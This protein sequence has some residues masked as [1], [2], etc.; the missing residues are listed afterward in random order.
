[1]KEE[2]FC[3]RLNRA[4]TL[5]NMKP[6]HLVQKT[7]ISK[8][9]VNQYVKGISEPNGDYFVKIAQALN[10]NSNWLAGYAVPMEDVVLEDKINVFP[11]AD[12]VIKL[13][14]LGKI[15]AGLPILA[16]EN[17]EDYIPAPSSLLK[18]DHE[19]FYLRVIGD[20]MSKKFPEGSFVLV[21]KQP[22]LEPNEIGVFRV[23]GD[24]AT[25][26]QFKCEE[27]GFIT[28][29]PMS[30]NTEHKEQCYNLAEI[31][32]E[33]IGKVISYTGML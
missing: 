8:Q 26:K 13:P 28:L 33:I 12:T 27:D 22:I 4:L 23:N 6:S 31:P 21:Q 9:S 1:M 15:S 30:Y 20:S 3:T 17:I 24:D 18:R 29:V 7:G 10:V 2:K 32:V 16:V 19:Y 11:V 25:V 14:A 5:R